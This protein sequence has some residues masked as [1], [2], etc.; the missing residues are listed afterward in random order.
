VIISRQHRGAHVLFARGAP[1]RHCA[2]THMT[3]I[4]NAEELQRRDDICSIA[5][6]LA[7]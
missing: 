5:L 1:G 2:V 3:E 4:L 6:S 7:G